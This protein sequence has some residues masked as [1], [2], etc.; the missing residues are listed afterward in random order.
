MSE[1]GHTPAY[2]KPRRKKIKRKRNT[3]QEGIILY[4]P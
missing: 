4:S 2:Y 1:N 3:K